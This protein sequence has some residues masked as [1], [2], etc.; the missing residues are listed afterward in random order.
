MKLS[1]ILSQ[2]NQ[3]ERSKFIS[4]LDKICDSVKKNDI[5]FKETIE[6][7][8]EGQLKSASGSEITELFNLAINHYKNYIR[9]QISLSDSQTSLLINILS[10]DGNCIARDAWIETLYAKEYDSLQKLSKELESLIESSQDDDSFGRGQRLSV[11]KDCLKVAY[12]NDLKANREARITDEERMILNTLSKRLG[13]STEDAFAIENIIIPLASNNVENAIN[14]LREKGVLFV[15]RRKKEILVA[16][17]VVEIFHEIQGKEL[18]D[19]YTL[20]ILRSLSDSELSNILKN[21]GQKSRGRERIEKIQYISHAGISVRAILLHDIYC[22]KETL[23]QR[24]DRLKTLFDE[25]NLPVSKL[26]TTIN[27]RIDI[28]IQS[29]KNCSTHEFDTLS[30]SG[31]S[32]LVEALSNETPPVIDRIRFDFEIEDKESLDP[33]RLRALG[34]SPVDILYLYRNDE[35]KSIRDKMCLSKRGNPRQLILE[36]FASANDKLIENYE[37]LARRD[38]AGLSSAG[39]EIKEAEIGSK[40]EEITRTLLEQLG[41]N[42]DEDLRKQ[43]NT[44]KD[45]TDIIISLGSDDVIIGEA[46]SFKNGQF[47]KYSTTSR[48]VKAYAS[49]C[50]SSGSRVAQVLIIA[51]EFSQDF[52]DSAEMDTDINIS[53]LEAEGLK[54]ILEAYK[55]RRNPKFSAKLF[56]KGGLLKADLIAK[57][58]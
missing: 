36:S 26:G 56:T 54:K 14:G 3:V 6:S 17:E 33:E 9:D 10:R 37:L 30:A 7:K 12:E 51:P 25:L 16:D 44:A 5:D 29:L 11:Y 57:T 22:E 48:Q 40:F 15:N 43:I 41:L 39:I 49:C 28:L 38:L 8:I 21:Y 24:K 47:S 2:I 34:I 4:C 18:P 13:I 27:E 55:S 50:E 45:K 20:R 46:K 42:V 52:I 31:F 1:Q 19:K 35:I 23:N 32:S 53:L 58:I